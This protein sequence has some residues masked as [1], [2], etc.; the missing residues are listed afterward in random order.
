MTLAAVTSVVRMACTPVPVPVP[1]LP[2]RIHGNV[3]LASAATVGRR[4]LS[5]IFSRLRC[6]GTDDHPAKRYLTVRR[7]CYN[8]CN[9]CRLIAMVGTECRVRFSDGLSRSARVQVDRTLA[10]E[11]TTATTKAECG[12]AYISELD[13]SRKFAR[14]QSKILRVDARQSTLE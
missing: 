6:G 5:G 12:L 7:G 14:R 3:F 4:Q 13:L 10:V 11:A 9:R 2:Y 8:L 1:V